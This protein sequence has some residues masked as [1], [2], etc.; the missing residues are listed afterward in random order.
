MVEM[1]SFS[2][3]KMAPRPE[4]MLNAALTLHSAIPASLKKCVSSVTVAEISFPKGTYAPASMS[5]P[6]SFTFLDVIQVTPS[7]ELVPCS[8][9]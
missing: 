7:L 4:V 5:N 2:I 6:T 1:V 8:L 3:A 9:G